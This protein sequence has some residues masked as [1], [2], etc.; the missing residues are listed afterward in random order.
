M[1]FSMHSCIQWKRCTQS[2]THTETHTHN[3]MHI[4]TC[5]RHVPWCW[6]LAYRSFQ[7]E[8]PV[9]FWAPTTGIQRHARVCAVLL[10]ICARTHTSRWQHEQVTHLHIVFVRVRVAVIMAH[11][12]A[13]VSAWKGARVGDSIRVCMYE[14]VCACIYACTYLSMFLSIYVCAYSHMYACAWILVLWVHSQISSLD[15]HV[16]KMVSLLDTQACAF[17]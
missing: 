3:S 10:G 7:C 16:T 14:F 13:N 12:C 4:Y 17:T 15:D 5:E 11:V 2:A 1:K 9:P 8:F 6:R